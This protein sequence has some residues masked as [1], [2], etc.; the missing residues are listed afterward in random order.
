MDPD[1][2]ELER[3]AA[4]RYFVVCGDTPLAYRLVDE[5]VNQYDAH[6]AAI[7]PP[8][9]TTWSERIS[10][11]PGVTVVESATLDQHAFE[12]ASLGLADA[13]ALVDQEDAGNVE[14]AL[15]AQDMKPG[16]RVV[17]RMFNLG[18]GERMSQ[19]LDNCAVL[20]AAAIAAPAFVAAALDEAATA[21]I[22]VANR[23]LVAARR[24]KTRAEDVA[25]GLAVLGPR[26]TDPEVLPIHDE[27]RTDLVLARAKPAAPPPVRRKQNRLR[28]LSIVLDTRLRLVLAAFVVLYVLGT[29]TLAIASPQLW[30]VDSWSRAAYTALVTELT[31][32]ADTEA[33]GMARF[34]QAVLTMVSVVLIPALTA[35]IVDS[36]VRA[37]LRAEAGALVG[38]VSDHIV[39]VG[40]G[41]VGTRVIR[42]L[43]EE[44][45]DVVA[46]ERDQ[47]ARGVLLA[48]EL[49]IPVII[50]D[51][52]RNETLLAAS[53]A[54][55]RAL[56]VAS[57]DDVTNLEV[58]LLG[59]AANPDLRVVLRLF[60]G[61]FADRVKRAFSINTSRSVSYLAAPAFAAAMLSR[62][63]IA[64]IPVRRR[65]LLL[66]DV[67][68]G[69][70]SALEHQTVST[71]SR[72]HLIRLL[73]IRTDDGDGQVLWRPSDARP[74]KRTDRLIVVATRA[75]LSHLLA[76]TATPPDPDRTTPY[77]LLEPH[78]M[79]HARP[80]SSEGPHPHP[81]IG[82][83]A[84]DSTRPA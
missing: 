44:G 1:P 74:L 12:R 14:A 58:A 18:L 43:H 73:A 46:V 59:R 3:A 66:A 21:P 36:V 35:T 20:S 56:V 28:W 38:P 54:T 7:F 69:A 31:G 27:A 33:T 65:V 37:R 39:V 75:G 72:Q 81:P 57:T 41:D 78:R 80:G 61:D 29:V 60:D 19:L 30:D 2:A 5:L 10:Q 26:G 64:T 11:V 83:A 15:L 40:L 45:V 47:Q 34:A 76:Q 23:T 79:P 50:G 51:A 84:G 52:S 25:A 16:I 48:R 8:T 55:C 77:R 62:Q 67:P 4:T 70:D 17:I 42:A 22:R 63:I 82:P 53:I 68:I 32:N 9:R 49:G 6:V 13:I 24:A 71:V